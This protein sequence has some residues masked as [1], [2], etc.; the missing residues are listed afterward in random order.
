MSH[1]QREPTLTASLTVCMLLASALSAGGQ[2]RAP[3]WKRGAAV[4]KNG[5][6][7]FTE[8]DGNRLQL[9]DSGIDGSPVVS[10]DGQKIA[11]V[12][13]TQGQLVD[14][15]F[16][17]VEANEIWI[18][19]V[20]QGQSRMLVRGAK[21]FAGKGPLALLHDPHFSPEGDR[22]YFSGNQGTTGA[23]YAA[24]LRTGAPKFISP[25]NSI[26]DVIPMG[27]FR[28]YLIVLKHKYL[29]EGGSYDWFWLVKPDGTEVA[30]LG[31][32]RLAGAFSG[33]WQ[34]L[35]H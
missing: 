16:G 20:K 4:E 3:I 18:M 17:G 11:F 27:T 31:D 6:I 2:E 22:L 23:V 25:G 34:S 13:K 12:R 1:L 14:A 24:D 15:G 29:P 28:A 9:T 8:A 21:D 32:W 33:L 30:P 7:W 10:L 35:S 26:V 19:D 5:N